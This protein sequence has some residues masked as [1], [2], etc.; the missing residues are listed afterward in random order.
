MKSM[1]MLCLFAALVI[2]PSTVFACG[3]Y[4]DE[5]PPRR[6]V[7]RVTQPSPPSFRQI[8]SRLLAIASA[9]RFVGE[10]RVAIREVF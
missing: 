4:G 10:R 1:L 6:P 7:A 8:L 3:S 9:P 5:P 2:A